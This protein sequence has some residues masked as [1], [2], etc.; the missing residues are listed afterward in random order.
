MTPLSV[1][2]V[3][4]VPSVPSARPPLFTPSPISPSD[5]APA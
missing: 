2:S 4:F 1:V 3:V 5:G